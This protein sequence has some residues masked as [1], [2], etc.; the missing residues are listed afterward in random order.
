MGDDIYQLIGLI[1]FII[2]GFIFIAVGIRFEDM[3]TVA[4]S[5]VWTLSCF[6][7]MIPLLRKK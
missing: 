1:G 6:V 2:A 4:G 5:V 3:L 7:W